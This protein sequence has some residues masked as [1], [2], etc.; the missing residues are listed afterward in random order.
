MKKTTL[1]TGVLLALSFL[2]VP[3]RADLVNQGA[4][5]RVDSG[6][7]RIGGAFVN[8]SGG[9]V[10]L[11]GKM[12][13]SGDWKNQ[14]PSGGVFTDS[15]AGELV[16]NGGDQALSGSTSFPSLTKNV[17]SAATLTFPNG[18]L[19]TVR[20]AWTMSGAAGELL[21]LR[22]NADSQRWQVS[23][24]GSTSLNYL[25]VKDSDNVSGTLVIATAQGMVD[26]GDNLNWKF[27]YDVLFVAG[28]RGSLE[29]E[30]VQ[31]VSAGESCTTVTAKPDANCH[32][33][34][35]TKDALPYSSEAALTVADVRED[36]SFTANFALDQLTVSFLAGPNGG[37][38]GDT[39]QTVDYGADCSAVT[40][41]P[42]SGFHFVQWNDGS[43]AN[44]LTVKNVT[45]SASYTASFAANRGTGK[46]VIASAPEGSGV[47]SPSGTVTVNLD[48]PTLVK[49]TASA[50]WQFDHWGVSGGAT[51]ADSAASDG[52]ITLSADGGATA[53]FVRKQVA[54]TMASG[55][56][57]TVSPS[58]GAHQV[59]AGVPVSIEA[60]P[61]TGY[62]F[63]S[64]ALSGA[65]ALSDTD[66]AE[67]NVTLTGAATV[68]AT[69]QETAVMAVLSVGNVSP[70]GAGTV[71]PG[72]GAL[73]VEA[74]VDIAIEA[75][76][77]TGY[78]FSGWSVD[79]NGKVA[80]PAAAKTT[81]R[82]AGDATLRPRFS[83]AAIKATLT[84][85]ADPVLGG[86]TTPV[87]ASVYGQG[88][89]V[90]VTATAAT[91]YKFTEWRGVGNLTLSSQYKPETVATLGGDAA[92]TAVFAVDSSVAE[93]TFKTDDDGS[94]SVDGSLNATYGSTCHLRAASL[95]GRIFL[96]WVVES[97]NAEILSPNAVETDVVLN[98]PA[99]VVAVYTKAAAD[100]LIT[101]LVRV[102]VDGRGTGHDKV[103]VRRSALALA[104]FTPAADP[105][106]LVV[107]GT[108]YELEAEGFRSF[109]K[110]TR[111]LY[112]SDRP[113]R[114]QVRL[115][116]DLKRQIFQLRINRAN[117]LAA[118]NQDGINLAMTVGTKR[119]LTNRFMDERNSRM[120]RT[121][122]DVATALPVATPRRLA[123]FEVGQLGVKYRDNP[124]GKDR[125]KLWDGLLRL[126]EGMVFDAATDAVTVQV[127]GVATVVK[128]GSF[129]QVSPQVW[130]YVDKAGGV[131]MKFDFKSGKWS[132]SLQNQ[133][134]W[135]NIDRQ[136]L[137]DVFLTVGDASA[138]LRLDFGDNRSWLQSSK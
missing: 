103:W 1:V 40:A 2:T 109:A 27:N 132:F 9:S 98:G 26:A 43:T 115:T 134:I 62:R 73:S 79:G 45:S 131:R 24:L 22:S 104:S 66:A 32:F 91:G 11:Q 74:G 29:G 84:M 100:E 44:P 5:L 135:N 130:R 89:V 90:S 56:G 3:A 72:A 49:A 48:E 111:W 77:A 99:S 64:W 41:I 37:L 101:G 46:L 30:A 114:P 47:T 110:G 123:S 128:P 68:T 106:S 55:A 67:A 15:S 105:V 87:G 102:Y 23:P 96:H 69:F 42:D 82:L 14:S 4:V 25:S 6:T 120:F 70:V 138:G 129:R 57:G 116:L 117:L 83:D 33:V 50:N 39:E 93:L 95:A 92:L 16:L 58:V 21:S 60:T 52:V 118:S 97:G 8:Q 136:D 38:S 53:N 65:G 10:A 107:E 94:V 126:P 59:E 137:V 54:L 80:N 36:M 108:S 28:P 85:A 125:L 71:S 113:D 63:V 81:I 75:T 119:F 17:S 51:V 18:A 122:A 12:A 121:S 35:W 31:A 13:V 124:A 34:N 88:A 78:T 86:T 76:A 127:G 20:G 133:V 61:A 19:T 7:L 112:Q